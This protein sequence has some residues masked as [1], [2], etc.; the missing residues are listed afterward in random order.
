[1]VYNICSNRKGV[2]IMLH[3]RSLRIL[4]AGF[5]AV[6]AASM[7]TA[8]GEKENVVKTDEGKLLTAHTWQTNYGGHSE[9]TFDTDGTLEVSTEGLD[10][11]SDADGKWSLDGTT[12]TTVIEKHSNDGEV[13]DGESKV[14]YLFAGYI[15]DAIF[16]GGDEAVNKLKEEHKDSVDWYVSDNYLYMNGTVWIPKK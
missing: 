4:A 5:A 7:L 3:K 15:N 13:V 16:D 10:G 9:V 1:M 6:M 8:C 12:L 14:T 11:T 2:F